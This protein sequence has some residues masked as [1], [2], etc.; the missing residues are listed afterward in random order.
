MLVKNFKE[1]RGSKGILI[2]EESYGIYVVCNSVLGLP[3]IRGTIDHGW[4]GSR[5]SKSFDLLSL[6]CYRKTLAESATERRCF[7]PSFPLPHTLVIF[8]RFWAKSC[9]NLLFRFLGTGRYANTA[10]MCP[11]S[12]SRRKIAFFEF[13]RFSAFGYFSL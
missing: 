5:P 8:A 10:K 1:R 12:K 7:F 6:F 9:P 11:I 2:L 4:K 3:E 13:F